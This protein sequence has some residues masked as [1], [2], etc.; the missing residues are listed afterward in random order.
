MNKIN[1]Y[2]ISLCIFVLIIYTSYWSS[3]YF[4]FSNIVWDL[5]FNIKNISIFWMTFS[6][7]STL[8]GV[9]FALFKDKIYEFL[10][11]P[12]LEVLL[13]KN[14]TISIKNNIIIIGYLLKVENI[15]NII[16]KD[17]EFFYE[18]IKE[19]DN[20]DKLK[21]RRPMAWSR[22]EEDRNYIEIFDYDHLDFIY[23][24]INLCNND[25]YYY[26]E[27][28]KDKELVN[29]NCFI[30]DKS[31]VRIIPRFSNQHKIIKYNFNI[32]INMD[33]KDEI[34]F[35]INKMKDNLLNELDDIE[36]KKFN[37]Q[38]IIPSDYKLLNIIFDEK[39]FNDIFI[40][41]PKIGKL[42]YISN[43]AYVDNS[44]II[45]LLQ[46]FKQNNLYLDLLGYQD[47][48]IKISEILTI[49]IK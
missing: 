18:S 7:I 9:L 17:V 47:I 28:K 34:I 11:R 13:D 26:F 6:S 42:N 48:L 4:G 44:L 21:I 24:V 12:N 49:R 23:A 32:E 3:N 30:R 20:E 40:N 14:G 1:K 31:E 35:F 38:V 45:S 10:F 36:K 29:I 39:K 33:I 43:K 27:S 41:S 15:T 46:C 8:I 2:I 37:Y 22:R 5:N 25:I 19:N 16:L